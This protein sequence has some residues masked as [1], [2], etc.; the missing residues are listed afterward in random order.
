MLVVKVNGNPFWYGKISLVTVFMLHST[1]Q[2]SAHYKTSLKDMKCCV[3]TISNSRIHILQLCET[4]S[5]IHFNSAKYHRV[6]D[7]Y[8]R[9]EQNVQYSTQFHISGNHSFVF[10]CVCDSS[11]RLIQLTALLW[12]GLHA[13]SER[14]CNIYVRHTQTAYSIGNREN[15]S[16]I[17]WNTVDS[18]IF[19]CS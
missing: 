1:I 19:I 11:I 9:Y 14:R 6:Y 13:K 2:H 3:L 10:M 4:P 12:L 8:T 5:W 7:V 16:F 17:W 18:D 15:I